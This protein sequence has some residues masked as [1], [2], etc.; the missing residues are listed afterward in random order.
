MTGASS[1][2]GALGRLEELLIL[3]FAVAMSLSIAAT[4][5]LFF[6]AV[7][8]RLVRAARGEP[9]WLVPRS[10]AWT[11]GILAAAWLVAGVF[12][13]EPGSSLLRVYRLYVVFVLFLV[14][15]RAR[16]GRAAAKIV[17][18]YLVGAGLGS[19]YGVVK[20]L[21]EVLGS[22]P[23]ER[24]EG[25]FSTAMTAGNVLATAFVV[26]LAALGQAG[27]RTRLLAAVSGVGVGAALVA[28]RTRSSWLGALAGA[29]TLALL[30]RSRRWVL[31]GLVLAL[32]VGLAVTPVRQRVASA[33]NP[34]EFTAR[35][36]VS[37]WLTGWDLY[38]ERP[39]T[40]WG[41]ADHKRRIAEHRRPDATFVAGHFHDNFVQVAVS[42][43]TLGLVAY[44]A[45]HA[46]LLVALWRRR[47]RAP[48]AVAALGVWVSFQLAGLFDWSFG[49][50]E[51][52]Y[53]FFFWMG[54]GLADNDEVG[55]RPLVDPPR[56][57]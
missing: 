32:A 40:G 38:R 8:V 22:R 28:T 26:V 4:E 12:S 50:A 7:A 57:A 30:G 20:W 5:I 39:L 44:L 42:T 37:L 23:L 2:G 14:A 10:V 18:A 49:D 27:V 47:T 3:G 33:F 46:A 51:V 1:G 34:Q 24:L 56:G 25:G 36:R 29:L 15:D 48:W 19:A 17:A 45:L 6:S 35:G 55:R 21:F 43:G 9:L 31:A 13:P 41:L 53:Q 11:W 54:L 52:V 16:D